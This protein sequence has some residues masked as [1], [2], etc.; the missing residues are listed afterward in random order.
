MRKTYLSIVVGITLLASSAFATNVYNTEPAFLG[1]IA[2]LYYLEDFNGYTYGS[3]LDGSQTSSSFGP[4]N[5]YSWDA[6]APLGLWSNSGALSTNDA[7]DLLT[8][9]FTGNPVTAVGGIFAST[10]INGNIIQQDVTVSLSDGTSET[11][12]GSGF[13]GFT[14][15]IPFAS[16]TVDGIDITPPGAGTIYNWPQ[17]DHF[18]VGASTAAIPEPA[19]MLLLGSG[20]IGM[21]VYAR[22]RF[23]KK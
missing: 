19:T 7:V 3:P 10:D 14:S 8:I 21:G 16:L 4:V 2:P 22:R 5:G 12:T 15:S 18:Y 17:V 13:L 1:Q 9:T 6:S 20:L 23:I 11:I